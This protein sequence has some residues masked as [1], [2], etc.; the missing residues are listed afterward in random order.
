MCWRG[1]ITLLWLQSSVE[2]WVGCP[3]PVFLFRHLLHHAAIHSPFLLFPREQSCISLIL[4]TSRPWIWRRSTCEGH[5]PL[6]TRR[7]KKM[8]AEHASWMEAEEQNGVQSPIKRFP[9]RPRTLRPN[10]SADSYIM[11]TF[12][13]LAIHHD[14]FFLLGHLFRSS[15]LRS[16]GRLGGLATSQFLFAPLLWFF[17]LMNDNAVYLH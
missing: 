9:R 2:P 14:S 1:I 7:A 11:A 4:R 12:F 13:L 6:K 17:R 3:N 16:S 10:L 15:W 5:G 8:D